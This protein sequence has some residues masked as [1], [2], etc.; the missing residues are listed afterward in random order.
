[1][2]IDKLPF[3][4]PNDPMTEARIDYLKKQGK[5]PFN[6]YQVPTAVMLLKQGIGRLIRTSV[7][8]GMMSVLDRRLV[9]RNYGQVFLRNLPPLSV[10]HR[11][12]DLRR[13]FEERRQ[14][15][16]QYHIEK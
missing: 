2:I 15:Y 11:L 7:D 14:K 5:D 3:A 12:E 8:Y 9:T 13:A 4:A 10:V 6:E 16:V 1:V